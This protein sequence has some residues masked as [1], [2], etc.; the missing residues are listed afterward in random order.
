[1]GINYYIRFQRIHLHRLKSESKNN[2]R[3]NRVSYE[4]NIVVS[5]SLIYRICL[6]SPFSNGS[7]AIR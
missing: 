7:A 5:D 2:K 1:M 6:F 4:K 3:W